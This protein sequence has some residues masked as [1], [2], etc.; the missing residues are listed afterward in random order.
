MSWNEWDPPSAESALKKQ[1]PPF[2]SVRVYRWR[3]PKGGPPMMRGG[4]FVSRRLQY[5]HFGKQHEGLLIY[6]DRGQGCMA[7]K[8]VEHRPWHVELDKP[9]PGQPYRLLKGTLYLAQGPA[10]ADMLLSLG[11]KITP[12]TVRIV[13]RVEDE[14]LVIPIGEA[15]A[16]IEGELCVPGEG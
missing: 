1:T 5:D 10:T 11:A 15:F 13:P 7:F 12:R 16:D 8:P 6:V 14:M 2:V 4:I 9:E 3:S